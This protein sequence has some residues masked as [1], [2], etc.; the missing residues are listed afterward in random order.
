MRTFKYHLHAQ[1][2]NK[3][4]TVN[5]ERILN[6]SVTFTFWPESDQLTHNTVVISHKTCNNMQSHMS[7]R[8]ASWLTN[9][10]NIIGPF[11]YN[12]PNFLLGVRHK[13]LIRHSI[14]AYKLNLSKLTN[15]CSCSCKKILLR[16]ICNSH[17]HFL[18][19]L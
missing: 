16:T 13:P 4:V 2:V 17:F 6:S 11:R 1:Q 7:L 3:E 10:L 5:A 19:L 14:T 18:N 12:L 9:V 8:W 15:G